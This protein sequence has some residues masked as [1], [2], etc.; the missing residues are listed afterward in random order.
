MVIKSIIAL[1]KVVVVITIIIIIIIIIMLTDSGLNK[2]SGHCFSESKYDEF[3]W[4]TCRHHH[5]YDDGQSGFSEAEYDE[6]LCQR[7][8]HHHHVWFFSA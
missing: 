3:L 1:A 7:C 6:F 4:Q 2:K 8:R 5:H